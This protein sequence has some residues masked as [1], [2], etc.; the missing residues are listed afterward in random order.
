MIIRGAVLEKNNED[1][2]IK[3]SN[4][5]MVCSIVFPPKFRIIGRAF[6]ENDRVLL[7]VPSGLLADLGDKSI[8]NL[9]YSGRMAIDR[10]R[11]LRIS[12]LTDN[13]YSTLYGVLLSSLPL[14][15]TRGTDLLFT[16]YISD[17]LSKISLKIFVSST[18]M[19]G[20]IL[21]DGFTFDPTVDY[22][23]EK[24][25]NQLF[26][27]GD[28]L[29]IKNLKMDASGRFALAN[30][31][32]KIEKPWTNSNPKKP[33]DSKLPNF[34]IIRYLS[35]YFSTAAESFLA[36]SKCKTIEELEDEIYFD[37]IGKITYIDRS[38]PITV[39]IT[40]YTHS[41][42]IPRMI[43]G[44]YETSTLLYVKL[45]GNH[46]EKT[47]GLNI[48]DIVVFK[49]LKMAVS[50]DSLSAYMSE[51]K[52]GSAYISRHS[53]YNSELNEREKTYW[54]GI[55]LNSPSKRRQPGMGCTRPAAPC[56]A[57]T[58]P[59]SPILQVDSEHTNK[60]TQ[61]ARQP[62]ENSNNGSSIAGVAQPEHRPAHSSECV[63][64]DNGHVF[65]ITRLLNFTISGIYFCRVRMDKY[66]ANE[67]RAGVFLQM[68]LVDGNAALRV[69]ARPRMSNILLSNNML[70][71]KEPFKCAVLFLGRSRK[72]YLISVFVDRMEES[73]LIESIMLNEP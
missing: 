63:K 13:G 32:C 59:P 4:R 47:H 19:L 45:F 28:L 35:E 7:T 55:K 6:A 44:T 8:I 71:S 60:L 3:I 21:V 46:S 68:V 33:A 27:A 54:N 12:D 48:G 20:N 51:S 2:T 72:S 22:T 5:M 26:R 37:I 56:A 64:F 43:K 25:F 31:S 42:L 58:P 15:Y 53:K 70:S 57:I 34:T 23:Q 10:D 49:N 29:K 41:R 36:S 40:D 61:Q 73:G 11:Y 62:D 9:V 16:L 30:K 14:T 1:D 50:R 65:T 18:E 38:Y 39:C 66:S 52:S 24:H 17:G 69:I 67:T